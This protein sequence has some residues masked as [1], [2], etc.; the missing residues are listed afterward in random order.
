M[1]TP[2]TD[3]KENFDSYTD[4]KVI[5]DDRDFLNELGMGDILASMYLGKSRQ[6]LNKKL[7]SPKDRSG[8]RSKDYLRLADFF[9]LIAAARSLGEKFDA[10]ALQK[11]IEE[12]RPDESE[13]RELV[14]N[15]LK[16][17]LNINWRDS[18]GLIL[19]L[20]DFLEIK[21]SRPN[22]L[23][24][25]KDWVQEMS[26]HDRIDRVACICETEAQAGLA[27][28]ELGIEHSNCFTNSVAQHYLPTVFIYQLEQSTPLIMVM[29]ERDGMQSAP[30]FRRDILSGCVEG[31]LSDGGPKERAF[32][33]VLYSK[34]R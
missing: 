17:N 33:R 25:L 20:P 3:N 7:G 2:M 12:T 34:I 30:G 28:K 5:K 8:T 22:A 32:K 16:T 24:E 31:I 14:L 15:A 1:L 26:K 13:G 11:Y 23:A 9:T 21:K 6:T 29:T 18:Y 27:G 10:K 19:V 4:R